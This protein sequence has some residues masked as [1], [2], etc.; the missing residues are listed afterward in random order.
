MARFVSSDDRLREALVLTAGI[1]RR[2]RPLSRDRAKA[3]LPVAGI[4][5]ARRI[6]TWVA[7]LAITDVVMNLHHCP[8]TITR[9]V[10][11]GSDLGLR[12]RYSWENPIL[13][14]AGG[15][16]RALS[17]F[18]TDPILIING[19]MLTDVDVRAMMRSHLHSGALVTMAVIANPD[20]AR[21]GGVMVD[22]RG[23]VTG[24][25]NPGPRN[26]GHHFIG[27]QVAGRS[28]FDDVPLDRP[29]ETV[30]ELYPAL[31]DRKPGAVRAFLSNAQFKDIG[32]PA[33]YL[34]TSLELAT[35]ERGSASLIGREVRVDPTARL[36]DSILWDR[37][38]IEA[39]CDLSRVIVGDDVRIPAGEQFTDCSIVAARGG[40]PAAGE[41]RRGEL[42]VAPLGRAH[43]RVSPAPRFES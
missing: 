9:L 41:E 29:S 28:A 1:G 8:E 16:R 6:L 5:L 37:V 10:G 39:A 35:I 30:T 14:S 19:D 36:H 15:P 13:G 17:F 7:G 40:A 24:F 43:G 23:W 20:P 2:L 38:V 12:V 27:I 11:D 32:T 31:I 21:Y 25:S 3:A 4:P 33:D 18:D 22:D 42:I 34:E 26:A